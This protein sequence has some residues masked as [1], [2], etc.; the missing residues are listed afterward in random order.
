MPA[1]DARLEVPDH[2][3]LKVSASVIPGASNSV[4]F[5]Q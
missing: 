3:T 4:S 1:K 5:M 2:A